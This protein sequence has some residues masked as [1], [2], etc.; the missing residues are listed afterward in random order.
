MILRH[1]FQYQKTWIQEAILSKRIVPNQQWKFEPGTADHRNFI[2]AR[3]ALVKVQ[4]QAARV[5][6][7]LKF[8]YEQSGASNSG[9]TSGNSSSSSSSSTGSNKIPDGGTQDPRGALAAA[10]LPVAGGRCSGAPAESQP[11]ASRAPAELQPSASRAPAE[12]QRQP[13]VPTELQPSGVAADEGYAVI[14][15]K[16]CKKLSNFSYNSNNHF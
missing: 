15:P 11:S 9:G 1:Y 8:F 4:K 3:G 12:R 6:K 5:L 13:S 2:E 16:I 7:K 10:P 14:L